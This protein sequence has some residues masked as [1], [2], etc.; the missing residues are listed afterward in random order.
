VSVMSDD[1]VEA[2]QAIYTQRNL[3]LYDLVVLGISNKFIWQCPTQSLV[4]YYN[5]NVIA[6]RLDVGVGIGYFLD[7]C[8]LP[9]RSMY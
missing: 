4:D 3:R 1:N 8:Q 6:N 5:Q 7:Q 9:A 2:G